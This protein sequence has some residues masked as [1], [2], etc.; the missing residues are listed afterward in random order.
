M[1]A[2][3]R[4]KPLHGSHA[5]E[6][7]AARVQF[8]QHVN[9]VPWGKIQSEGKERA[10]KFQLLTKKEVRQ[11]DFRI[12]ESEGH[13]DH[14]RP[15]G[16]DF[17]RLERPNFF[18]E[19]LELRRDS[20]ALEVF[21]YVRWAGF[22][23]MAEAI[24]LPLAKRYLDLV[25]IT[26]VQ[27]EYVDRFDATEDGPDCRAVIRPDSDLVTRRA[28]STHD[29]WHSHA[30]WFDWPEDGKAKRLANVDIDV[31]DL[32]TAGAG[33]GRRVVRIRTHLT[34]FFNQI[35]LE[36]LPEDALT[37][38]FLAERLDMLH[39][40]LKKMLGFV[41]TDAASTSVSLGG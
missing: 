26:G 3:E 28:F 16:I 11:V 22:A 30:G 8:A 25:P 15:I 12:E 5:I 7:V 10:E 33:Q 9:D 21:R 34:D 20:L 37:T 39:I 36:A 38:E 24:L 31:F 23:E 4:W 32:P 6:R 17:L 40:E 18:S 2:L 27:L 19:K 13:V 29:P 1:A 41:L 14:S 35:G